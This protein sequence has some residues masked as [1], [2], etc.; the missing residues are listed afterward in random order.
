[1]NQSIMRNRNGKSPDS[2]L[3]LAP[4]PDLVSFDSLLGRAA[5]APRSRTRA[6][7]AISFL[8]TPIYLARA[9]VPTVCW[10]SPRRGRAPPVRL[11]SCDKGSVAPSPGRVLKG[12]RGVARNQ[13]SERANQSLN[14]QGE[15]LTSVGTPVYVTAQGYVLPIS[16]VPGLALA[17]SQEVDHVASE[18]ERFVLQIVASARFQVLV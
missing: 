4:S 18:I 17:L 2:C 15:R 16:R 8:R 1:M 14:P 11:R 10:A 6:R 12:H 13:F 5:V 7:P 9:E 3:T